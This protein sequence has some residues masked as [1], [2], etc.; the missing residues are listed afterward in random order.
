VIGTGR[1]KSVGEFKLDTT[2]TSKKLDLTYDGN[3]LLCL[4][5]L[6]GDA[7]TLCYTPQPDASRPTGIKPDES[8]G[9]VVVTFKRV[10]DEKKE[11]KK[12]K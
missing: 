3:K 4:Y 7:L 6:D 10:K 1:D 11:E 12:D 5:E 9:T 8:A 2:A